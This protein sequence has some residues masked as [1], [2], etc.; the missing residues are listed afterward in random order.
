MSHRSHLAPIARPSAEVSVNATSATSMPPGPGLRNATTERIPRI[1]R[2]PP[3][4]TPTAERAGI[5]HAYA[6]ATGIAIALGLAIVGSVAVL[7][8]ASEFETS[9]AAAPNVVASPLVAPPRPAGASVS[10]AK[11]APEKTPAAATCLMWGDGT[12]PPPATPPPA[13]VDTTRG[14]APSPP[15]PAPRQARPVFERW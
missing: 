12:V 1:R 11:P 14:R 2:R 9:A 3:G 8:S 7:A 15:A 6:K 10:L 4:A 13:A 5:H